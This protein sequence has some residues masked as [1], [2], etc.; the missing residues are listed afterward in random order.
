[1]KTFCRSMIKDQLSMGEW[2]LCEL[3]WALSDKRP[4]YV[5]LLQLKVYCVCQQ[6]QINR[7]SVQADGI[8]SNNQAEL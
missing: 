6:S 3:L 7:Q 1:M 4:Y 5:V 8:I 2:N